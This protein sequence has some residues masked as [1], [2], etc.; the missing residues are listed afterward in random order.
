MQRIRNFVSERIA[1]VVKRHNLLDVS[2]E[3]CDRLVCNTS[4]SVLL[5][6]RRCMAAPS[7]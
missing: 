1:A 3:L 5:A 4:M 6:C 2:D 7:S